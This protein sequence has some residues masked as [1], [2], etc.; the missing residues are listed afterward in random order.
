MLTTV[1]FQQSVKP[2][3][4]FAVLL[5][6]FHLVVATVVYVTALSLE[7]KLAMLLL[8]LLSLFYY[9]ARDALL[10]F[11]NSWRNISFD[12][13]GVSVIAR[14]GSSFA[15]QVANET[16]VSTYF[17]VLRV[18][19]EGQRMLVSRVIFPDAMLSGAFRELCIHLKF[20]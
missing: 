2:S 8:I 10:I 9:M 12:Q 20:V 15:G 3:A 7:F 14:D 4:R 18:R 16:I 13:S 11:P 19:L 6:L 17:V 5:L 1:F